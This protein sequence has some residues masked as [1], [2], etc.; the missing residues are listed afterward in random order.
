MFET[1]RLSNGIGYIAPDGSEMRR[2]PTMKG[3]GLC[4]CTL[5][6]DKT[7]RPVYHRTVDEIW[8]FLN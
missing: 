6:V 2:L 1:K 8:C 4:H 7:S 3:G 5:R